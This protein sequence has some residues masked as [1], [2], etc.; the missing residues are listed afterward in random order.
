M[1][2]AHRTSRNCRDSACMFGWCA[3]RSRRR[4]SPRSRTGKVGAWAVLEGGSATGAAAKLGGQVGA[5]A[6]SAGRFVQPLAPRGAGAAQ[7]AWRVRRA[8]RPGSGDRVE[9]AECRCVCGWVALIFFYGSAREVHAHWESWQNRVHPV[10]Q[11]GLCALTEMQCVVHGLYTRMNDT[12]RVD[13]H[14]I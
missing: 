5:L 2:P 1:R 4:T 6:D 8:K 10:L 13:E 7:P 12:Y 9:S 14:R 3:R 11:A